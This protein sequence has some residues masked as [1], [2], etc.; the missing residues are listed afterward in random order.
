MYVMLIISKIAVRGQ[1]LEEN[2]AALTLIGVLES[3]NEW[4]GLPVAKS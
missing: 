4:L 2:M 3:F 1:K